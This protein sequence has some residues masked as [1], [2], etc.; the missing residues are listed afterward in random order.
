VGLFPLPLFPEGS[1]RESVVTTVWVGVFVI[2]FFNIRFGWT[3]SGLVIPGYLVPLMLTNPA[4]AFCTVAEGMLAYALV[5]LF[6]ERLSRFGWWCNYFGRDRFFALF[7]SAVLIRV[8]MD[9]WC[10]PALASV[11]QDHWNLTLDYKSNFHSFGM[12]IVALIANQF[13]KTGLWR[14]L[15]PF[16][17]VVGI[18]FV[19]IRFVLMTVTNFNVGHIAYMYSDTAASLLASPKS[20][21]ILIVTGF[22]ASRMNLRY[23]WEYN[24]ILIPALLALQWYEPL[25]IVSSLAEAAVTYVVSDLL[26]RTRLFRGVTMEGARKLLLFFNVAYAYRFF[27][28]FLLPHIS[29]GIIVSDYYGFA[30]LLSSLIALKMHS[31]HIVLR[32]TRATIQTSFFAAIGA[33]FLGLSLAWLLGSIHLGDRPPGTVLAPLH[34]ST[35]TLEHLAAGEKVRLYRKRGIGTV[36]MPSPAELNQF[37]DALDLIRKHAETGAR[38]PLDQ[39]RGYLHQL[40]YTLELVEPDRLC[41]REEEPGRGW[42]FY[43]VN[44]K[45]STGL[46]VEVP[47]PLEEWSV[48]E[49]AVQLYGRLNGSTLAIAGGARLAEKDGS[50]D[51][52]TNPNT[53]FEAFHRTFGRRN[54][55]QVRGYAADASRRAPAP[56]QETVLHVKG[57]LPRSLSLVGLRGEIGDFQI[58]WKPTSPANVQ[59]RRTRAGFAE[60]WLNRASRIQLKSEL[61]EVLLASR[62]PAVPTNSLM[63]EWLLQQKDVMAKSGTDMYVTP[64]LAEMTYFDEEIITPLL[65]VARDGYSTNGLTLAGDRLIRAINYSTSQFGY[66][67]SV[68]HDPSIDR[69]FLVL[70]ES[71]EAYPRRYWGTFVIRLGESR[72]YAVQVPRPL[73]DLNSLEYGVHIFDQLQAESILFAGAHNE[74]NQSQSS[75]LLDFRN[76]AN[77]FSLVNQVVM[78]EAREQS[79]MAV[80]CRGYAIPPGT[81]APPEVMIAFQDG[82]HYAATLTP[83][84]RTLM[85]SLSDEGF[86]LRIVDGSPLAAGYEISCVPQAQY[87]NQSLHKEF[88]ILWLSPSLREAYRPQEVYPLQV[89]LQ[90]LGVPVRRDDLK[91]WLNAQLESGR[92]TKLPPELRNL[93]DHYVATMDIVSL[94]KALKEWPDFQF[95]AVVDRNS[96]QLLLLISEKQSSVPVVLNLRPRQAPALTAVASDTERINRFLASRIAW[97]EWSL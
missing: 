74:A 18:T 1:L 42:G 76:T 10:L 49:S 8:L 22:V 78:R 57:E 51:V 95:S 4:S 23:G 16:V 3:Y 90:T 54:V 59:S 19:L 38:E 70:A 97:L 82:I 80:Q 93:L 52:L 7:L 27:L 62:D 11:L 79:K 21:I 72:P 91:T 96:E 31:K 84:G 75:D 83:L 14:G 15:A 53:P 92:K 26:L 2:S 25:K 87:L 32:L 24:G 94:Q 37:Q 35:E 67:L 33:N 55:L 73:F 69:D 56:A 86:R 36:T 44:L 43:V 6:S 60:L 13:W 5:Y 28:G 58:I 81:V 47:A 88:A 39:A 29:E 50:S 9:G 30:Y 40:H 48:M 89:Q 34:R 65:E 20:Y 68:H 46:L 63:L 12:I 85:E 41:L 61:A 71:S 45:A 77:L 66:E 64:S 17:T